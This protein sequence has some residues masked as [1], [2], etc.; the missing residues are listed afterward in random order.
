[1]VLPTMFG[2]LLRP[3]ATGE[4]RDRLEL[5]AVRADDAVRLLAIGEGAR[6]SLLVEKLTADL[7]A[8]GTGRIAAP[9]VV[10]TSSVEL[11]ERLDRLGRLAD[12][13][14]HRSNGPATRKALA[15]ALD[16]KDE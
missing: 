8:P 3:G 15:D 1:F 16:E 11:T 6:A 9:P 4:V 7:D 12:R 13:L 5:A 10:S 14:A 2:F